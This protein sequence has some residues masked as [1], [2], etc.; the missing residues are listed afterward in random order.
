MSKYDSGAIAWA[1][2]CTVM[3]VAIAAAFYLGTIEA[4]K[5]YNLRQE[6]LKNLELSEF[7]PF[8]SNSGYDFYMVPK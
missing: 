4:Q 8:A 2:A 7:K 1:I 5:G 3:V 6:A